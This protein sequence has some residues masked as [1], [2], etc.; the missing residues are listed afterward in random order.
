MI[1]WVTDALNEQREHEREECAKVADWYIEN[2]MG[3]D[4]AELAGQCI[5][6]CIRDRSKESK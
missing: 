6:D 3:G 4:V 1:E 5:A 2:T